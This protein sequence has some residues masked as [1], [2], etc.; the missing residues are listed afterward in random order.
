MARAQPLLTLSSGTTIGSSVATG[1]AWHEARPRQLPG[2][3]AA[4]PAGFDGTATA[5]AGWRFG[6]PVLG[7]MAHSFIQA[8]AGEEAALEACKGALDTASPPA[9]ASAAVPGDCT[10]SMEAEQRWLSP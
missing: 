1:R 5:V 6:I 2:A 7:T 3:R 4:Y 9:A 8:H 10:G